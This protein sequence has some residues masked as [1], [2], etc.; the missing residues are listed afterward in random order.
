[1]PPPLKLQVENNELLILPQSTY[2]RR[3]LQGTQAIWPSSY[4]DHDGILHVPCPDPARLA[5]VIIDS[6]HN[7]T[8]E[9]QQIADE[10]RRRLMLDCN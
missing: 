10:L 8:A 4:F 5:R 9:S 3:F 2:D 6:N 1:M 7:K